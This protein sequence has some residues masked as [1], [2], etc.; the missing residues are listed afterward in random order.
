MDK[1]KLY[2]QI[3]AGMTQ[4][5]FHS[6]ERN[7]SLN[8]PFITEHGGLRD[9]IPMLKDRH[10]VICGAGPSL[11]SAYPY[12]SKLEGRADVA[13]IAADMAFKPLVRAGI[14]PHF[15]V[16]CETTP[17]DFFAGEDSSRTMLLAFSCV[18]SRTV[19]EWK[20]GLH[21]YNWLLHGEPYDRLWHEAGTGLGFAAT[22]S[23]VTSQ[24]LSI[25]LGCG[26][27]TVML[28]GNDL[29]F[30]DRC[31]A[32]GTVRDRGLYPRCSRTAPLESREFSASWNARHYVIPRGDRK[33]F[34][35]H[36]FLAAKYWMEET[37]SKS[38][39]PVY[40]ASDPGCA[41]GTVEKLS[42]KRYA[43]MIQSRR[44]GVWQ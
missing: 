18:C 41:A 10:V 3:N 1:Q 8:K 43:E 14:I 24:A 44:K 27:A 6:F 20:G 16:S 40:D 9:V 12:I 4:E 2:Q 38:P 22:G 37:I 5:R 11:E 35:N 33:F 39:V 31:Y 42:M 13:V 26:A 17:R 23:V 34:T 15:S 30:F 7:L 32:R 36:Q 19:R 25:A 28:A 21:F 29:G